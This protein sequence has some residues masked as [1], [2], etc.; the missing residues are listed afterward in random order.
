M[1]YLTN[2]PKYGHNY[3]L[4]SLPHIK[5]QRTQLVS[6]YGMPSGINARNRTPPLNT[7]REISATQLWCFYYYICRSMKKYV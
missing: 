1:I 5:F 3:I 7:L 2:S 6:F 4:Y